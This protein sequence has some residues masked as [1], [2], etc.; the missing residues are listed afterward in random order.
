MTTLS[1][2]TAKQVLGNFNCKITSNQWNQ[3]KSVFGG[4]AFYNNGTETGGRIV[5]TTMPLTICRI[6]T[7]PKDLIGIDIP[8]LIKEEKTSKGIIVI[9]GQDPFRTSKN[10]G[11]K[12][13][14]IVQKNFPTAII[15][16]PF[17]VDCRYYVPESCNVYKLI[18]E[19]LLDDGYSVYVTD[20]HKAWKLDVKPAV[21]QSIL[22]S[23]FCDLQQ[24]GNIV[25]VV[26]FGKEAE[27]VYNTLRCI[28]AKSTHLPHPSK[29]NWNTLWKN[30]I[31]GG[32]ITAEKVADKSI[33]IIKNN[34]LL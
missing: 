14:T 11:N 19:Q 17:A 23:E 10:C 1:Y 26:T 34:I 27:K 3:I 12:I 4:N 9:I 22:E 29:R 18:I 30:I 28:S 16:T 20:A 32:K 7:Q 31:K 24:E 15:G 33:E 21:N 6:K 25:H 5:Y 2:P 13:S 8:V